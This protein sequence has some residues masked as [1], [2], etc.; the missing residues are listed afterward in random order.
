M[1]MLTSDSRQM[2]R[3]LVSNAALA[4]ESAA[5]AMDIALGTIY[6]VAAQ[7]SDASPRLGKW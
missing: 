6:V 5:A 7:N 1:T 2:W 3:T 4:G